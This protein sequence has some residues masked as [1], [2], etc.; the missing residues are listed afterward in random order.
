MK[1]NNISWI[2]LALSLFLS[3]II[4][5]SLFFLWNVTLY[6]FL[7]P[8]LFFV[9]INTIIII[10]FCSFGLSLYKIF[11]VP[12]YAAIILSTVIYTALQFLGFVFISNS[13]FTITGFI[14][15]Q[16]VTLFIYLIVILPIAKMGYRINNKL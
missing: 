15:Y 16:M 10:L 7:L 9:A 4:L 5:Y 6:P 8:K 2:G 13:I 11:T 3:F 14:F 12:I 1:K